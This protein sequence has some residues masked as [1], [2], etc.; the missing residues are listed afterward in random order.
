MPA[1]RS[2]YTLVTSLP[3][4]PDFEVADR[5]PIN[6][7]RLRERLQMLN[8]DDHAEAHRATAFL[9]WQAQ[10]VTRTDREIVGH[11]RRVVAEVRNPTLRWLLTF[12]LERRTVQ[13]ALRRRHLGLP[14]PEGTDWGVGPVVRSIQQRWSQPDFGLTPVY[15]WIPKMVGLLEAGD[16][17]GLER[18][19]MRTVWDHHSRLAEPFGFR[20]EAVLIYL[21]KWD[22]LSRWLAQDAAAAAT[23]FADLVGEIVNDAA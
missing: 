1:S 20:F 3:P 14:A 22:I 23:R 11:Y 5:L 12:R 9:S 13:A 18:L 4:L 8:P 21:F 6:R 10:P 15:P 19:L 7:H 2:Y 16:T 17:M